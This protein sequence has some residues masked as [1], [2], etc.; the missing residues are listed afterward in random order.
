MMPP[1]AIYDYVAR[2]MLGSTG[3]SSFA[4]SNPTPEQMMTPAFAVSLATSLLIWAYFI[5]IHR[6]F[7]RMSIWRA[8]LLYTVA[9]ITSYQLGFWVMYFVGY[10]SA[11]LLIQAGIV[12]V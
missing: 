10:W 4:N 9:A 3:L 5:A 8:G 2:G 12:T 6:R 7:W 11:Y 1:Y